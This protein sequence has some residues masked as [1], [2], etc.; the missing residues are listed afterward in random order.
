[1]RRFSSNCSWLKSALFGGLLVLVLSGTALA[2]D[3]AVDWRPTYDMIMRWVNFAILVFVLFKFGRKPLMA[4]LK[5][6]KSEIEQE[7]SKTEAQKQITLAKVREAK[8]A[9]AESQVR[10]PELKARLIEQG[11]RKRQE[12]IQQA[13]EQS[14]LILEGAKHKIDYQ[15]LRAKEKL[16]V[17]LLDLA[18][19]EA[20]KELP[21]LITPEDNHRQ[22][23]KYLAVKG[24]EASTDIK[25]SYKA[26]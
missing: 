7:F 18:V 13:Q 22:I 21:D 4:F 25:S 14:K 2:A 10:L 1:M 6:Q 12:F 26:A 23:E 15:I 17:E 9:L 20:L 24:M 19:D 3:G 8:T 16:R 5:G 11:E